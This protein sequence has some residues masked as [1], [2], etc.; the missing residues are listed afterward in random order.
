MAVRLLVLSKLKIK[1]EILARVVADLIILKV[2]TLFGK[3]QWRPFLHV[4]DAGRSVLAALDAP[5][6]AVAPVI[7]NIACDEQNRTL[8]QV[9]APIASWCLDRCCA[10]LKRTWIAGITGS[11]LD[12]YAKVPDSSQS[13][14]SK[15]GSSRCWMRCA[16]AR[17][18]TIKTYG[19]ATSS[20]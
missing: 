18:L 17:S 3:D 13:G 2:V 15:R 14:P 19:T 7:F 4:H 8:G 1:V 16:A 5:S 20:S 9:G 12:G 10:A 11:N 6:H